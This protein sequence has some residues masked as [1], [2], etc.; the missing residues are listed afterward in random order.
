MQQISDYFENNEMVRSLATTMLGNF[1]LS[2]SNP[3]S[4]AK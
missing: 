1:H 3:T 4:F 2:E